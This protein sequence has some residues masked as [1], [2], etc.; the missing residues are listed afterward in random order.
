LNN[1]DFSWKRMLFKDNKVWLAVDPQGVVVIRNGKVLIKYQLKQDHEYWVNEN[2]IKPLALETTPGNEGKKATRK[3]EATFSLDENQSKNTVYIYTDGACSGNPGPAGIGVLLRFGDKEKRISRFIG[4]A[5]NNIAELEAIR[6]GLSELRKTNLPV[7]VY[8]DSSYAHGLLSKGW[9]PKK[10]TALVES[11]R[12][13]L[14][15]FKDVAFIKVKGHSGHEENEI[16]D[17]LA[18]QAIHKKTIYKT[19]SL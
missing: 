8:T 4:M 16:V 17:Q 1:N 13:L 5:T 2:S 18:V 3:K 10:N 11:I 14:E 7:R 15:K 12:R 6:T 19:P 9:K